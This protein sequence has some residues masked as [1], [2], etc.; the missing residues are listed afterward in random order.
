MR[1]K[2]N[3]ALVSALQAMG[4]PLSE[5][6]V[7]RR[8]GRLRAISGAKVSRM[9]EQA[10]NRTL[11]QRTL[12]V[13]REELRRLAK[14]ARGEWERILTE[15][16]VLRESRA[17]VEDDRREL[18]D[19]LAR[20]AD[21]RSE[22]GEPADGRLSIEELVARSEERGAREEGELE[23]E[24]RRLVRSLSRGTDPRAVED[25]VVH[26]S[27]RALRETRRRA[28]EERRRMHT[29]EVDRLER[30][31]AK[32]LESLDETEVVL[33][34]LEAAKAIDVG[35]P[36]LYRVVQGLSEEEENREL[37]QELM[38]AIF[39]ANLTLKR[40]SEIL[41]PRP[42]PEPRPS[43]GTAAP[44]PASSRPTSAAS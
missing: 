8:A 9:I 24:L 41:Q 6:D 36:S 44:G 23:H 5:E 20:L 18:R 28:S 21:E 27:V 14:E 10:V 3:P 17:R 34:R 13:S 16:R 15:H 19:V 42:R 37:K 12:N 35:L 33:R 38:A 7:R 29:D 32:L 11:M 25:E 43:A 4:R 39:E 40:E 1:N 31:V 30:R 26:R 2:L 22:R